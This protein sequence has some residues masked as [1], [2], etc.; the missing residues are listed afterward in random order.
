MS[1]G[2]KTVRTKIPLEKRIGKGMLE[3][4]MCLARLWSRKGNREA[5]RAHGDLRNTV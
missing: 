5:K 2:W 3:R 1:A 4:I